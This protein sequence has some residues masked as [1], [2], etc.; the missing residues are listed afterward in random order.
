MAGGIFTDQ[1]FQFNTKCVFFG[2]TLVAGYWWL[3]RDPNW[4]MTG[5][6]FICSYIAMAWYDHAYSCNLRLKTGANG[7]VGF[8][9]SIWKPQDETGK[10]VLAPTEQCREYTRHVWIFQ[11]LVTGPLL[12]YLSWIYQGDLQPVL[13]LLGGAQI[14]FG[15]A[16]V[17]TN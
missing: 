14:A 16:H 10:H 12:L 9:D 6:I 5:T 2:S 13:A 8:I 1:P 17:L 4:I 7:P 15:A 11:G 3:G